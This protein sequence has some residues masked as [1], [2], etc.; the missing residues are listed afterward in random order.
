MV[1]RLESPRLRIVVPLLA[2]CA[3][4]GATARAQSSAASTS[5]EKLQVSVDFLAGY[6]HD[7][8]QAAL[9]FEKQGRVAQATLAVLRLPTALLWGATPPAAYGGTLVVRQAD[10]AT[11]HDA[12]VVAPSEGETNGHALP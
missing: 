4:S 3:I 5:E 9:G 12:A 11:A 6:G 2:L 1:E 7:G 8:A 10:D